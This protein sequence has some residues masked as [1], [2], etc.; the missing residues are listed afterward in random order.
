LE[1]QSRW[2]RWASSSA[3]VPIVR[4]DAL[5]P[6]YGSFFTGPWAIRFVGVIERQPH[7]FFGSITVDEDE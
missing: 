1:R 7:V 3:D 6:F 4:L 5:A 2:L